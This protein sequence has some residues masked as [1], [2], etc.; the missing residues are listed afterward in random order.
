MVG[1]GSHSAQILTQN[2]SRI[3]LQLQVTYPGMETQSC[4][5]PKPGIHHSQSAPAFG[6]PSLSKLFKRRIGSDNDSTWKN[7][8]REALLKAKEAKDPWEEYDIVNNCQT[9]KAKRYR[10]NA[11]TKQWVQDEIHVKMQSKVSK[12]FFLI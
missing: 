8:W 6:K 1:Y 4:E 12:N 11:L 2:I 7:T 9:E 10:Y 3:L 5:R